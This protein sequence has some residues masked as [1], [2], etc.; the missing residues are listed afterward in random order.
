MKHE[1]RN[2]RAMTSKHRAE[3]WAEH[4]FSEC[5]ASAE[6][7]CIRIERHETNERADDQV[8]GDMGPN[9]LLCQLI[10]Y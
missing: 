4:L 5:V 1:E 6:T 8:Q 10:A 9:L 2:T 7:R 3:C